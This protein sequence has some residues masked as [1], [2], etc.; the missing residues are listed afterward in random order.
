MGLAVAKKVKREVKKS[1]QNTLNYLKLVT[2]ITLMTEFRI[3]SF[4]LS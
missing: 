3:F 4:F 1:V 2:I